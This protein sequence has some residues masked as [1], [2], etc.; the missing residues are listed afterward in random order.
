MHIILDTDLGTDI[1]DHWALGMLLNIPDLQIDLVLTATG[2][3]AYRAA[4]AAKLL[5]VAGRNDIPVGIGLPYNQ[6]KFDATLRDYLAGYTVAD[7]QCP[8]ITDG[9]A[10][11]IRI[12]ERNDET[13][14]IAIAPMTNLGR[15]VATRPDLASKCRVFSMA[16]SIAKNFRDASGKIAE[17]NVVC[18]IAASQNVFAANWKQFTITPLDHCG[19]IVLSGALYAQMLHSERPLPR[20]IINAYRSWQNYYKN[21]DNPDLHSSIL[22]DTVAVYLATDGHG[23]Q[24]SDMTLSV[25]DKGFLQETPDGKPVRVAL[26]WDDKPAYMR[27]LVAIMTR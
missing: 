2:D 21:D 11:A 22:Y 24:Y 20:E 13:I 12:I 14:I 15:I 26:N 6:D 4:L 10:E 27:E 19:N 25:D 8:I 7:A 18:D 16:G 9:I 3:T 23:V 17:Y 5:A 1:D